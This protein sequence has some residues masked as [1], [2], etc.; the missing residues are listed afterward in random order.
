MTRDELIQAVR[1]QT[2]LDEE[3]LPTAI[4]TLYLRE[5]FQRTASRQRR[6]PFFQT[7][8]EYIVSHTGSTT[9]DPSTAEIVS[10]EIPS[11]RKRLNFAD[12][13][14]IKY[15]SGWT[16]GQCDLFSTWAGKLFLWAQPTDD[17]T[18]NV[19]GYRKP[20]DTWLSNPALQADLDNR[21]HLPLAHYAT[22]LVYAQQE[23]PELEAM[24]LKR[25]METV[26]EFEDDIMK[27]TAYR[28]VVLNGGA[29]Q[30]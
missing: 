8:W 27:A 20:S 6:W 29:D 9:L 18:I 1:A 25:W 3:D 19:A 24:Y 22:A 26:N 14:L 7:D 5:A 23:D 16:A 10:V 11:Q 4:A 21:L 2:D 17:V 13:E 12:H 15:A 28:P 30:G